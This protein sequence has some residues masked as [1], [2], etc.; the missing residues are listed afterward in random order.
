MPTPT[1]LCSCYA[2]HDDAG[3]LAASAASV[4]RAG[5]IYVFVSRMPW[6]GEAGDWQAAADAARDAGAEVVV[7]DWLGESA[8][9]GAALAH[10][11][12]Q[13]F[14][15]ALIPDGDE[16]VEPE[17]LRCLAAIVE[18]DLADRVYV[19]WDTYW[20]SPEYVIRPREG[21]TPCILLNLGVARHVQVREYAG[22]RPL[23]LSP[24]HGLIHHLSYV[25]SDERI[26]RKTTTWSHWEEVVPDWF[27][28][29]WEEWDRNKLL[30]NLHPTHPPA[31][32]FAERIAPPAIFEEVGLALPAGAETVGEPANE[33]I[34][35]V[36]I[37]IPIHG[38]ADDIVECLQSLTR[39]DDLLREVIIVDNAS[40]DGAAEAAEAFEWP[41]TGKCPK[42]RVVRMGSNAGFAAACN[43]GASEAAGG[44][45]LFLNSDTVVPRIGLVRLIEA[46]YG[47]GPIAAAGPYTNYSG[48]SQRIEPTY[49]SL[50]TMDLFAEDFADR[51][52]ADVHTDML[53]GFCLAVKRA[54]WLEVGPFDE[55][56]GAGTFE[57]NDLC[58]RLR[59]S[60]YQLVIAAR[61]FVHH[62][63]SKTIRRLSAGAPEPEPTEA[64]EPA[65]E[66]PQEP[67]LDIAALMRRNEAYYRRKWQ[68][69]L[70]CGFASHLAGLSS[71]PVVFKSD[72]MPEA[73]APTVRDAARRAD[74]SL[75]MIVR[76]EDRVL[77]DCLASAAPFFK[78]MI[79]VDTGSTDRT[80]EIAEAAGAKVLHME[81]PDSFAEARTESLRHAT[82]RW[83]FWMDA[84]DTLPWP[85][86]EE[87]LRAVLH[88]P[89]DVVAF[90]VPVQFVENG[91]P[92]GTRVDHVKLFRNI[93]TV[94]FEGRI[95]EQ[96]LPTIR[97][98]R[99]D[100]EIR[101]CS[102]VVLH[103]GY[104]TS[105]EGQERKRKRD[106]HLLR[107]DYRERPKHPF[108]R[109]N[110][111]MTYHYLGDH[112]RAVRWLRRCLDV[113]PPTESHVRKAYSLLGLSL[114]ELGQSE[115][116]VRTMEQ[117]LKAV[118]G[119]AELSFHIA[120]TLALTADA[121]N[122]D[123][124]DAAAARTKLL[125]RAKGHYERC[126]SS[127]PSAYFSSMDP[128]ILGY[129]AQH[130]LAGVCQALGLYP[131][132]RDHWRK[133]METAPDFTPS[134]FSLFDAAAAQGDFATAREMVQR[135]EQTEGPGLNSL[136]M[137]AKL[138]DIVGGPA[139]GDAFLSG[140][141]MGHPTP[142]AAR[143]LLARRL[144]QTG[145]EA[146][147]LPHLRL[148]DQAGV[149]E[150]AY[151]LGVAATPSGRYSEA[152][153]FMERSLTLNPGHADTERE[154][155]NLRGLLAAQEEVS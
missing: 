94:R 21:F 11:R 10:M 45:L 66:K 20:K 3:F 136:S 85:D 153:T 101:R 34:G 33:R 61:G 142:G 151:L 39:S 12:E 14:T 152:L 63:G 155:E 38:G 6:H 143:M 56:F 30:R 88:A 1:R 7:G 75:C 113:S 105:P 114:R 35:D 49:T 150:A 5:P 84:D 52:A 135:V 23:L 22:G 117:G 89:P 128:A 70:E 54:A 129:K 146:E 65:D 123:A 40:P 138:A 78:E 121:G 8:H 90:I 100:G 9:R 26:L 93:R 127:E 134:A 82:G 103:S 17:L 29:V 148:L 2:V 154:I 79:L 57:D 98:A 25:G 86:G 24:E 19:H 51:A 140:A 27:H 132:A 71:E 83:I 80:V 48:H 108:V 18:Q 15:H 73:M 131:E 60:G 64:V 91:A 69:D 36:S 102:A 147:A 31:Y 106:M 145:R 149:A 125:N 47:P 92:S 141:V 137:Q 120:A 95:H 68:R 130:N 118:G 16:I 96:V 124:P 133:A 67:P 46:L 74:I 55:G 112:P 53:V 139:N 77:G 109:F 81:W 107:L 41:C 37:V 104:D 76:N 50:A 110:I 119:D 97:R 28:N 111:G 72:R 115:E 42:V 13:G 122:A 144:L 58:Y 126:L 99:P 32:G 59:R 4:R 44:T 62:H 87:L 43:R 116:A